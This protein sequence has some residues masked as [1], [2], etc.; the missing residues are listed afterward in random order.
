MTT[1]A[2]V[3]DVPRAL[4]ALGRDIPAPDPRARPRYRDVVIPMLVGASDIFALREGLI[5]HALR[6]RGARVTFVLCDGLP[7]CDA[8]TFDHDPPAM[9]EGCRPRGEA[10]LRALG[11]RVVPLSRF[12]TDERANE[13]WAGARAMSAAELLGATHL[14]ARVGRDVFS[15]T[16]R[17]FRAGGFDP[18]DA[19]TMAMAREYGGAALVMTEVAANAL[20]ELGADR[21]F[22]SHGIYASWGPWAGA[23]R[24]LGV[25]HAA[26]TAGW[27]RDTLI[28]GEDGA[29]PH[30]CDDLW[31]RVR[32]LP[33][34]GEQESR[35]SA[36]LATRETN[37]EEFY[38][39]FDRVER[40]I[41]GLEER[42]GIAGSTWRRRLCLFPNVAFDA[43]DM[44]ARGAFADMHDWLAQTIA[45]V[46]GRPDVLLLVKVHPAER[47]FLETTPQEWTV[48]AVLARRVGT[49]PAN[50]SLIDAD[51][52]ISNFA[53]YSWI[54]GG[55]VNTSTV[56]ME[57]ALQGVPA[58][59]TGA[60]AHYERAGVVT[61]ARSRAEYLSLLDRMLDDP[62]ALRPDPE[63]ARRYAYAF[64][65]RQAPAF[66]P[67]EVAGWDPVGLRIDELADLAPGRFAGVDALCRT[68]LEGTP[69]EAP[70]A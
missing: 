60:G 33:L 58:L 41:A 56:G 3:L 27:R 23:A 9:C 28:V 59:A 65:F 47:R 53:L 18:D 48:P 25:P 68:I 21:V 24:A 66:E 43:A 10:N 42:L 31:E 61:G 15:S 20:R 54:D 22:S 37:A 38:R 39:Y 1:Q 44:D 62:A 7:V 35:L 26:Y 5:G 16:L 55:L 49:L 64:F 14:G 30:R 12:L 51:D 57:L 36:Y 19:R 6:M 13:L 67:I 40:D 50:V 46:A 8:R 11:H 69:L 17:Y 2:P 52:A 63:T 29:P 70:D 45:H 32:D 34:T 4:S